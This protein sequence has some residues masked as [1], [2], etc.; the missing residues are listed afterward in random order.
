MQDL[1]TPT[2]MDAQFD[3]QVGDMDEHMACHSA[4]KLVSQ[5]TFSNGST[6]QE[7]ERNTYVLLRRTQ[8]RNCL[9]G[10]LFPIKNGANAGAS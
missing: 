9:Q 7:C 8:G 6:N 3:R 5:L 10:A 2:V 1:L 4:K